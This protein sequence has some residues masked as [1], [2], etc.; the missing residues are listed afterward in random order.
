[1]EAIYLYVKMSIRILIAPITAIRNQLSKLYVEEL[2]LERKFVRE[3]INKSVVPHLSKLKNSCYVVI[4]T[5]YVD[6][7]Y[8]D[9][10]YHYY[11]SKRPKYERNCFRLSFFDG[12]VKHKDFRNA[13]IL[14]K[15]E[16]QYLGFIVL[17]PTIPFLIGRSIIAP[18]A[19]KTNSFL[20]CA[21][22]NESTV[23]GVKLYVEGFP[24]SSQ[25]TETITCAETTIWALMEYFSAKYQ[26]YKPVLPSNIIKILEN[27]SFERQLPSRGLGINN[28]SFAL[29]EF[30]FGTRI[31]SKSVFGEDFFNLLSCYIESGIPLIIAIDD[32]PMGTIRHAIICI[33]HEKIKKQQIQNLALSSYSGGKE[34]VENGVN[35]YDWDEIKKEF[36]FVDDNFPV[37]QCALLDTPTQHYPEKWEACRIKY[38]IAPLHSRIYL[39]AFVAKNYILKLLS[40]VEPLVAHTEVL[41]R[42]YLTSSRSYK[43]ALALNK[44]FDNVIKDGIMKM[45]MA[46]FIWVAELST[47]KLMSDT[48]NMKADGLILIDATEANIHFN[49]ALIVACYEGKFM[50]HDKK[51]GQL[52]I[53]ALPLQ[54]FRIYEGTLKQV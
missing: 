17:R 39:D 40:T 53:F 42:L 13:N 33:G 29:K 10:Y 2:G 47:K 30:G 25:D 9:S 51:N 26:E 36:V 8:R 31:Y 5:E 7:V 44:T 35:L 18:K 11:S 28:I 37:Y 1:L 32:S 45:E 19:L 27:S 38:F 4:E 15:L 41:I 46:K 16:S 52:S 3:L 34:L 48:N 12:E 14:S 49:K 43:H 20:A 23:N 50:T 54:P 21:S 24:H 6:K 22:K